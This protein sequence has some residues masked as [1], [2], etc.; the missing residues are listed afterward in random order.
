MFLLLMEISVMVY[1]ESISRVKPVWYTRF[2]IACDIV[3]LS[4]QGA[5]GGIASAATKPSTMTLGNRL[6]LVGLV[7]QIVSLLLFATM[8]A[9][10]AF[11]VRKH[12][13]ERDL[14]YSELRTSSR[15]RGFLWG[16]AVAFITIFTR[17]VYR[18]IELGGGW[19]NKL[20]REETTFI[21]LE[22][23]YNTHSSLRPTSS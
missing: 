21:I 4:L 22:S 5:G 6:V 8:C 2:F 14:A 20:M 18:V 7:L 10:F 19:N 11:R 3:S 15:F 23:W 1:G 17:C 9:E 16:L 13:A 12:A